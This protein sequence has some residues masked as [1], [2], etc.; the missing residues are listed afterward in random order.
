[1]DGRHM[2][3]QIT[4]YRCSH[5]WYIQRSHWYQ[6]VSIVSCAHR[7]YDANEVDALELEQY[8]DEEYS[9]RT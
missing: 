2:A 4:R 6:N 8:T 7:S 1:M 5:H 9:Y 3:W